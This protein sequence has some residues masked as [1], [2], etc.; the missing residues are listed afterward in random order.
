MNLSTLLWIA[1]LASA[2]AL[3]IMTVVAV[4][5]YR[6][7]ARAA[8][9]VVQIKQ[10][11]AAQEEESRKRAKQINAAVEIGLAASNAR[12]IS[13]QLARALN[14]ILERFGYFHA[15]IF[16]LDANGDYAVVHESTGEI[17]QK[18]KLDT[19]S[20][21]IAT[22]PS[23]V[24][25][26]IANGKPRIVRLA[27]D[28]R[29]ALALAQVE[30]SQAEAAIPLIAGDR[31]IGA[32]D[33]H[34][35]DPEFFT[36]TDITLL[37]T[38]AAHLA[39]AIDHTQLFRQQAEQIR[40][41]ER[42]LKA[43]QQ[44]LDELY[45]LAG[46]LT[47]D[48]WKKYLTT[49]RRE[50]NVESGASASQG[51][52]GTMDEAFGKRQLVVSDSDAP[53]SLAAPIIL[54]GQVIGALALEKGQDESWSEDDRVLA[55]EV[56]DRLA[57]AV[58]N[59]RLTDQVHRERERL[60]FLFKASQE[61]SATLDLP[62]TIR[63]LLNFAPRL[64]AD[65]AYLILGEGTTQSPYRY[66]STLPGLNRLNE[67]EGRKFAE[68][69]MGRSAEQ[70]VTENRRTALIQD[71]NEDARWHHYETQG[72]P[73][74]RSAVVIPLHVP[75]GNVT[76]ILGYVHALPNRFSEEQLP[77]FD[78]MATQAYVALQNAQLYEQLAQTTERLREVD[79]L[80]SQFLANMSHEL[81][82]PLNSIIG[83][84]RVIMKGIDGPVTDLQVQDLWAINN[85]GQHLLGMINDILDLSKIEAGKMELAFEK[86]DLV[87][88][89]KSVMTT[90]GGLI[91]DKPIRLN[92]DIPTELP[93]VY[94]DTIRVRQVLINLLSNASK[95][96][97]AGTITV[98]ARLQESDTRSMVLVSV[99]DTGQ[100]IA[101][102]D[103][104]KLFQAFSQVD[105]SPTRRTGGT[106]L[107]LAIS[108]NLVELHGGSIWV[109]STVGKGTT[110]SFT[111]PVYQAEPALPSVQPG[112][113]RRIILAIDD[114]ARVIDLYRRYAE[115]H[116]YAV[117]GIT[118]NA[119]AVETTQLLQPFV[120]LL[121]VIM[122]ERN[123]WQ[124][125]QELKQNAATKDF[126]VIICSIL[127]ERE[128]ALSL[129]A[130]ECLIKPILD[131]DLLSA[132]ERLEKQRSSVEPE[133]QPLKLS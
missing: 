118:D 90:T 52:N 80:K 85:S 101:Q 100:G 43:S 124:V 115:P 48:G 62:T 8:Q 14:L 1:T 19:Q 53:A 89:I 87:E 119:Q 3:V 83:F 77:L 72:T 10:Q 66:Y 57:L 79:R 67:D 92:A 41:H 99:N 42:L 109:E 12:N 28:K 95:F 122:Q 76:G 16:L 31:A 59:A 60:A 24:A 27:E 49:Q 37:Q 15:S 117:H 33:V 34:A 81:R 125:L 18:L 65:Y 103:L 121:D 106:G 17:G 9:T 94:V 26:A 86:V 78:S 58:D 5:H 91:K 114:D 2:T 116:G 20:F 40:E 97:E 131:V 23:A 6:A 38:I 44:A 30:G 127:N 120:I 7:A 108:R 13:E 36:S 126:P 63:T 50:F 35:R 110:F 70:W 130:A 123:G 132:F 73:P 102:D 55:Q 54:R 104:A 105:G 21:R 61:L 113:R 47:S 56:A 82:T 39:I 29:G 133:L 74:I 64:D 112:D 46:R 71:T 84:S 128:K 129:G 88:L 107:G 25:Y 4:I 32:L 96:T 98:R 68:A 45:T 11:S 69:L 111:L 93:P 22:S 75:S 51:V